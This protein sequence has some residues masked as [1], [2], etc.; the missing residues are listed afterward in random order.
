MNTSMRDDEIARA[1]RDAH[2]SDALP[3]FARSLAGARAR[4]AAREERSARLRAVRPRIATAIASVALLAIGVCSQPRSTSED[5]S[6]PLAH[7]TGPTDFLLAS[8]AEPESTDF[9]LRTPTLDADSR[10]RNP[11]GGTP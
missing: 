10:T 5:L 1:L 2:A 6:S 7:W 3:P 11:E 8:D 9:L 4:R